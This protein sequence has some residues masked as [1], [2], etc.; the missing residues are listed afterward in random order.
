MFIQSVT[1][2]EKLM[3][4]NSDINILNGNPTKM[5]YYLNQGN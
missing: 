3:D 4:V 2:Y 5:T 1:Q